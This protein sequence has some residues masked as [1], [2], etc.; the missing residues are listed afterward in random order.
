MG[1]YYYLKSGLP[2]LSFEDTKIPF[3]ISEFKDV[4]DQTL[5]SSD[6][7]LVDLYFLKYDN[8]NLIS[9]IHFPDSEPDPR[10]K[11]KYKEFKTLHKVLTGEDE[12]ERAAIE[13]ELPPYIIEFY[14]KYILGETTDDA[15]EE[16]KNDNKAIPLED[17]LSALYYE[18]VMK[19][20]NRFFAAWF[21]LNLNINNMFA[22][23]TCR[24]YDLDRV[25]YIVGDN[26][27]A[28]SLRTSN[29]RDFGLSDTAEYIQDVLRIVEE[30]DLLVR[31]R[32]V[33]QLK[34][35]WLEDNTFFDPFDIDSIFAYLLELEMIER[36]ATL[37]R[38]TGEKTFRKL[39]G[40]MKT[41]SDN[42]LEEFKRNNKK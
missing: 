8:K 40:S 22:A 19:C 28:Q 3:T 14:R 18:Y 37:D 35:K 29:A 34:W 36:W 39:V 16:R 4:L 21:E 10:G 12:S 17:L 27:I 5:T 32:K 15:D 24:K 2:T 9:Y 7:R 42:A 6:K 13:K 11:I 41:G 26:E 38:A 30:T 20:E 23:I 33:D 1:K 25:E 31:E